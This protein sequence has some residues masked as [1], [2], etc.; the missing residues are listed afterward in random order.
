MNDPQ[1][2]V[3]AQCS[4]DYERF[5]KERGDLPRHNVHRATQVCHLSSLK[6]GT[7]IGVLPRW[8]QDFFCNEDI[9]RIREKLGHG[10]NCLGWVVIYFRDDDKGGFELRT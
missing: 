6:P 7:V 5:L 4:R 2:Y 3:L 9:V 8:E 10:K 1:Y